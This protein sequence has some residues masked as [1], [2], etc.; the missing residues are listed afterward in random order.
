LL[1]SF[2]SAKAFTSAVSTA[3]QSLAVAPLVYA[4]PKDWWTNPRCEASWLHCYPDEWVS[5]SEWNTMPG[6]GG[7]ISPVS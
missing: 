3:F 1:S 7:W 6:A 4:D 5:V 2:G